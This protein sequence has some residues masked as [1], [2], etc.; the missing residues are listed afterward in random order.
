MLARAVT[1]LIAAP[2]LAA[3]LAAAPAAL[4][5]TGTTP[6]AACGAAGYPAGYGIWCPGQVHLVTAGDSLWALAQRYIGD[7]RRWPEIWILGTATPRPCGSS[8]NPPSQIFPGQILLIPAAGQATPPAWCQP[9][10]WQA[11]PGTKASTGR[12]GGSPRAAAP[13]RTG[14]STAARL[15]PGLALAAAVL[16]IGA[17]L[18]LAVRRRST[19]RP[20]PRARRPAARWPGSRANLQPGD[21]G[22]QPWPPHGRQALRPD[23]PGW[24]AASPELAGPARRVWSPALGTGSPDTARMPGEIPVGVRGQQE[25]A[26]GIAALRGV[27]LTGPGAEAAARAMLATVLSLARPGPPGLPAP[28][29]VPA[30]TDLLPPRAGAPRTVLTQ[31]PSLAAALD[32]T[33][34]L[35]LH[36]A[37]MAGDDPGAGLPDG[38]AVPGALFAAPGPDDEPRL[39]GIA[40]AGQ[41]VGLIVVILGPWPYG[42]TCHVAAD[43]TVTAATPPGSGLEG[44]RLFQLAAR[45]LAGVAAAISEHDQPADAHEVIMPGPAAEPDVTWQAP[46]ADE[47]SPRP[48]AGRAAPPVRIGVLGPLLISARGQEI[49]TGF[50]KARELL[51]FLAVCGPQGASSDAVTEALWPEATPGHGAR[52]RNLTLRKARE[53]LR[54]H[55]GTA[56]AMW[57]LFAGDRYRLDQNLISTDLWDFRAALDAARDAD[58]GTGRLAAYQQATALYRGQLCEDAGYEWAEPYAEAA[59][60]SVLDAWT[61]TAELLQDT[62]QALA[63][64]E[65]AAAYDPH[66]EDTYLRIM[67]LQAG[68]GRADAARRTYQLLL[69]RLQEL[70]LT[71]PRPAIRRAAAGLLGDTGPQPASPANAAARHGRASN[72]VG[73]QHEQRTR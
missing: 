39:R 47:H 49:S 71:G 46:D 64:L 25:A 62:D 73:G 13:A 50:R 20:R 21:P 68:A 16:A 59:R 41:D 38:A 8:A 35:I 9:G 45:D 63:A 11:K 28:V 12:P 2:V 54:A 18:A 23:Q 60:R 58:G 29:I 48:G 34:A 6:P 17:A 19:G 67:S 14:S 66:N 26:A 42:T 70:D 43:G 69:T 31:P 3:A 61:R 36:L 5:S 7:G 56:S 55:A 65:S 40:A 24:P 44:V 32:L 22:P 4:A 30:S 51:A 33:E 72:P 27:G 10:T 1:A 15:L 52:Q 57:I 53:V 37:R